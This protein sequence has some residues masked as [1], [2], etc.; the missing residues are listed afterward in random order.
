SPG[1][2]C[3]AGSRRAIA[4]S[5]QGRDRSDATHGRPMSVGTSFRFPPDKWKERE[6]LRKLSWLSIVL[7]TIAAVVVGMTVGQSQALKTAWISDIL[8]AIPPIALLVALRYELRPPSKRFPE[9]YARAISV[10]FL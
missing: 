3:M 2:E 10:A 5:A 9:G 7:L 6:S 4:R 8:T 1:R